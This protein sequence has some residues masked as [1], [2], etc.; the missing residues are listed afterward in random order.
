MLYITFPRSSH[1]VFSNGKD[2]F[3]TSCY[4]V[5]EFITLNKSV[6]PS[7]LVLL[8]CNYMGILTSK[9]SIL[10]RIIDTVYLIQPM[11]CKCTLIATRMMEKL[12]IVVQTDVSTNNVRSPICRY[13][14]HLLSLIIYNVENNFPS[15]F[16]FRN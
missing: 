5:D 13:W 9:E 2:A 1:G 3:L 6:K 7:F 12:L 11:I 10:E 15:D 4:V 8:C 14:L 16:L